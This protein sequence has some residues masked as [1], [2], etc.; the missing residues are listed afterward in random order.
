MFFKKDD[1]SDTTELDEDV[2]NSEQNEWKNVLQ[3]I[4]TIHHREKPAFI[5]K[6]FIKVIV[7][8]RWFDLN[9]LPSKKFVKTK[10]SSTKTSLKRKLQQS[11]V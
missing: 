8:D 10:I 6:L 1:N 7:E 9:D 5:Y 2:T 4:I 3:T 11:I